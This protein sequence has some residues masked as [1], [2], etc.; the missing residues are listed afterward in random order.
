MVYG[1]GDQDP[2]ITSSNQPY[3]PAQTR[4]PP[5]SPSSSTDTVLFPLSPNLSDNPLSPLI[6]STPA[7]TSPRSSISP[8][9]FNEE[10]VHNAYL[11]LINKSFEAGTILEQP[12]GSTSS[13]NVV[14]GPSGLKR[15]NI[16][17]E[18]PKSKK[19]KRIFIDSSDDENEEPPQGQA[20]SPNN[21]LG[22][23]A[24]IQEAPPNLPSPGDSGL[25]SD[26]ELDSE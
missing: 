6:P 4:T 14:A 11:N 18:G 15:S 16:H 20:E 3:T 25:G 17:V 19:I 10:Q 23:D 9:S 5:N 12:G 7:T 22:P 24:P 1:H 21:E 2:T 26:E 13:N 8:Y